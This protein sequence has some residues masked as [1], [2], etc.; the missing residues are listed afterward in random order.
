MKF[1]L[2]IW[3]SLRSISRKYIQV[4]N[5]V[6]TESGALV[7]AHAILQPDGSFLINA[8]FQSHDRDSQTV[9]MVF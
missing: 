9:R 1:F 6:I 5:L 7:V 2:A 3:M 8:G 4:S